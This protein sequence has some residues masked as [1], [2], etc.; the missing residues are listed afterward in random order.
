MALQRWDPFRELRRLDRG[1]GGF[2]P[3]MVYGRTEN[4]H[5]VWGVPLDVVEEDDSFVVRASTPGVAPENIDVTIDGSVLTIKGHTEAEA[6]DKSESYIVR[7]RRSGYF[8]RALRLSDTV[9]TEKIESTYGNGVL[10]ITISKRESTKA[11]K[12]DVKAGGYLDRRRGP[13]VRSQEG[14]AV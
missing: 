14:P 11:R 9:D 3:R 5:A 6:E 7:E 13:P 12:V 10:T 2:G 1:F 8:Q 4:G